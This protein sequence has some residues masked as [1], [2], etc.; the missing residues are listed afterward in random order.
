MSQ[1][2][3]KSVSNEDLKKFMGRV[4]TLLGDVLSLQQNMYEDIQN[5]FF[6]PKQNREQDLDADSYESDERDDDGDEI[7]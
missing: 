1:K 3:D 5:H 2:F 7:E 6:L 4:L